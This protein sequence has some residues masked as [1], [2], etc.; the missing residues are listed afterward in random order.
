[1]SNV[2]HNFCTSR[3]SFILELVISSSDIFTADNNLLIYLQKNYDL[4]TLL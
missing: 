3:K 4:I 1:M 2:Q